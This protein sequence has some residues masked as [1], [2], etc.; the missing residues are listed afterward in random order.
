MMTST[1]N[2]P[3]EHRRNHMT[4]AIAPI[5]ALATIGVTLFMMS[6][7]AQTSQAF[8]CDDPLA[9]EIQ[10]TACEEFENFLRIDPT[11]KPE[12]PDEDPCLHLAIPYDLCLETIGKEWLERQQVKE[13]DLP[14]CSNNVK[15]GTVVLTDPPTYNCDDIAWIIGPLRIQ[16]LEERIAELERHIRNLRRARIREQGKCSLLDNF[17]DCEAV[18]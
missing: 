15:P 8:T 1:Q 5:S 7:P 12:I 6:A 2:H 11:K 17:Q 4:R 18:K 9:N 3:V 16:K 13:L 10:I 14:R